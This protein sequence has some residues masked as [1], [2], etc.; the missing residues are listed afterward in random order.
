MRRSAT[1]VLRTSSTRPARGFQALASGFE[2]DLQ[3]AG[4]LLV[5]MPV[6]MLILALAAR[7]VVQ[8]RTSG[9]AARLQD[10]RS[11]IGL[12]GLLG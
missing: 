6:G 2:T 4:I 5:D 9:Q 11:C 3:K 1:P 7:L 10:D 8:M 12:A